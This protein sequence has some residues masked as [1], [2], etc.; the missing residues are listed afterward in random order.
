M[1]I[2][3]VIKIESESYTCFVD[4]ADKE[5]AIDIALSNEVHWR[6]NQDV[7]TIDAFAEEATEQELK[8]IIID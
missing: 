3:K 8:G 2:Y 7:E 4:A 6:N 1:S 5:E